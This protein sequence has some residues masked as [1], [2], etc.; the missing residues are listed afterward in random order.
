M[1]AASRSRSARASSSSA[2]SS[3][4]P[5]PTRCS[6]TRARSCRWCASAL[7]GVKTYHRR[8]Q[9]AADD[10][11][12]SPPTISSSP[13]T[14]PTSTPYFTGCRV[15]ISP[16]R[17]GAG[18]KGKVNLAM[19]YGLPV[20]AT[21]PSIE[22]MHLQPGERRARRRRS[23]GV[24]RGDRA[25]LPRRGAVGAARRGRAREHPRALLARRRAQRDHAADRAR[26]RDAHGE[27]HANR[28]R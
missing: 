24:R 9:G 2:A 4:R 14:C 22:G 23:E 27:P 25:A 20:V 15:S 28:R 17:Y 5:T 7:P 18:V 19:S 21:T 3:I 11:A 12:R 16:L 10:Q 26:A 6:G 13:A 1:P 8:Q